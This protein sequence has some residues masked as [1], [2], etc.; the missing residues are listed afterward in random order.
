MLYVKN[1]A[2]N[3]YE[4][5]SLAQVN[6]YGLKLAKIR[7]GSMATIQSASLLISYLGLQMRELPT[8]QARLIFV[9]NANRIIK[10]IVFSEGV[11][12]QTAIYP[13]RVARLAMENHATGVIIA[14]NHPTG[15]IRPSNADIQITRALNAAMETLDI[16][17]LDHVIIGAEEKGYF[18]FRENGII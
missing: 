10:D 12:D 11:E 9:D 4:V 7:K 13:R 18:S 8:E 5:A 1:E 2:T 16:R 6:E 14:H 15:S 3:S 17:F